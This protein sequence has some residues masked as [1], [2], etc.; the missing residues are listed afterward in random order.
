MSERT[1]ASARVAAFERARA[2]WTRHPPAVAPRGSPR[3]PPRRPP[4]P[5]GDD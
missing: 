4:S 3:R 1:A 5:L 2:A